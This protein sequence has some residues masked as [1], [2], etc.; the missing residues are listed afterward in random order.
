VNRPQLD[1]AHL[2]AGVDW[3]VSVLDLRS[4]VELAALDGDR[5][6]RTA[7]IGKV[8]LLL[9]IAAE[10][11]AGRLD[12]AEPL[13][14]TPPDA[15][16]DSGL[17]QSLSVDTL[18]LAD[19]CALVGAVSDNLATN[20][21]LRRVGLAAVDRLTAG[22]G[23]HR[24]ALLDQVRDERGPQHPP[25]LSR[26]CARE[27]ADLMA[28]LR[29]GE[30]VSPAVSDR[31]LGWLALDTDLSMVAAAFGLDP[32]AHAEPDRGLRLWNKT[33]T[34]SRARGDI[35]VVETAVGQVAYAVLAEWPVGTDRRDEVLAAMTAIGRSIRDRLTATG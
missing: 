21:L 32:L 27:L 18:P 7:S 34:I 8:F 33:G 35:G 17:W 11:E 24:C 4:G 16:A 10:L 25:T 9:T 23:V 30:L 19:V 1:L 14:R 26:G 3:S 29:R 2:P 20:V 31:V 28:R 15:V 22:L 6:L 12:G 5:V 13:R